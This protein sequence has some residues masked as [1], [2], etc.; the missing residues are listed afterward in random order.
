MSVNSRAGKGKGDL[1]W[2]NIGLIFPESNREEHLLANG[3]TTAALLLLS[4]GVIVVGGPLW[5]LLV[6]LG[7]FLGEFWMGPDRDHRS[8]RLRYWALYRETIPHHR[9]RRSHS[10]FPGTIWRF[11]YGFSVPL[12]IWAAEIYRTV[13]AATGVRD[14]A[15][16]VISNPLI[17]LGFFSF[18]LLLI[19]AVIS[20][21]THL[22]LDR[23]YPHEW[24][25]GR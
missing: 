20:D 18:L 1:G 16:A 10:I 8:A 4:V 6:P 5:A 24:L 19:G 13:R 7:C 3:I 14:A 25:K 15:V 12:A 17:T 9:H 23:Y 22:T 11:V 2:L 21:C